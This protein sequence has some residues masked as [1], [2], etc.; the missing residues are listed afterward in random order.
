MSSKDCNCE[1]R[2]IFKASIELRVWGGG[3]DP[4]GQF[5]AHICPSYC[6]LAICCAEATLNPSVLPHPLFITQ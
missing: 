1:P 4:S 2:S 3:R 6:I 5:F